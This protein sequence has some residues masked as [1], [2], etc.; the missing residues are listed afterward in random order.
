MSHLYRW[1]HMPGR[2]FRKKAIKHS[3][4]KTVLKQKLILL[5]AACFFYSGLV[6]CVCWWKGLQ[7]KRL[8]IL[9]YH[10]A[11][12]G[13]LRRHFLYL[14]RHYR[15]MNLEEALEELYAP[16]QKA[17][18]RRIPVAL[19]FDDGYRDNYSYAAALAQE[20]HIP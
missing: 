4:K 20:L 10:R 9:N 8:I 13:D 2:A 18:D 17:S 6:K 15:I 14:R 19:T 3:G 1:I 7:G 12:G 16:K 5:I 11:A